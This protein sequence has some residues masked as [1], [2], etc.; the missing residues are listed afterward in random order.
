MAD[1]YTS[2]ETSLALQSTGAP[3]D[4]LG[5]FFDSLA[6]RAEGD[7]MTAPTPGPWKAKASSSSMN[8]WVLAGEHVIAVTSKEDAALIA[9]APDLLAALVALVKVI[10]RADD[11]ECPAAALTSGGEMTEAGKPHFC[12][13]GQDHTDSLRARI[14]EL[15][16]ELVPSTVEDIARVIDADGA[17]KARAEKAEAERDEVKRLLVTQTVDDIAAIID[18]DGAQ[19]ARSESLA[20]ERD[21]ERARA[22]RYLAAMRSL[23][24]GPLN[25]DRF[26]GW[27]AIRAI[28]EEARRG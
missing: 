10:D 14:A 13:C 18:A 1:L 21:S 15:E 5:A 3:Q 6:R 19:K 27:D 26:A 23:M 11:R 16:A 28:V 17:Q 8:A 22:D 24:E 4:V 20:A 25:Q 12:V 9:A 2:Y 7:E